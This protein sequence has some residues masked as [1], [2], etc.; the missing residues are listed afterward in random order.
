MFCEIKRE[1][2]NATRVTSELFSFIQVSHAAKSA[3]A[4]PRVAEL[5]EP[6]PRKQRNKKNWLYKSLGEH[7]SVRL[8]A[9]SPLQYCPCDQD[10]S[11]LII[12]IIFFPF[13]R[14]QHRVL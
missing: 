2:N 5:S 4:T 8:C 3:R 10:A 6:L 12:S 11:V 14:L 1:T 9:M 7:A 13:T